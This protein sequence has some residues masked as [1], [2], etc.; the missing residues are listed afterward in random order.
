MTDCPFCEDGSEVR[1]YDGR[2]GSHTCDGCGVVF[3]PGGAGVTISGPRP[4]VVPR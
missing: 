2:H 4:E 3:T 1:L